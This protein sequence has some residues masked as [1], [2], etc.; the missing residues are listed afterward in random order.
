MIDYF[1][2]NKFVFSKSLTSEKTLKVG[3]FLLKKV[4]YNKYY[5]TQ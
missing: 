1:Q 4:M 2:Y 3:H 5:N